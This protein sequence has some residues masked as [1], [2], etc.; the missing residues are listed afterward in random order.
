MKAESQLEK[1]YNFL[2]E[3]VPF[4]KGWKFV[5][6]VYLKND[7]ASTKNYFI[8]GPKSSLSRFFN[9]NLE[10]GKSPSKSADDISY[11]VKIIKTLIS[12]N[13]D[14]DFLFSV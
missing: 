1:G 7:D 11:K 9:E 5:S 13:F 6:V 4:A 8:L 3:K 2:K 12:A 10:V 14:E